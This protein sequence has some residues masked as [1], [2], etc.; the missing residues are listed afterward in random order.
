METLRHKIYRQWE[1][2]E[3]IR[4]KWEVCIGN[5]TGVASQDSLFIFYKG[6]GIKEG[7]DG[8]DGLC[9]L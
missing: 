9:D 3:I 6:I 2:G 7:S 4:H 1:T 5:G 8:H